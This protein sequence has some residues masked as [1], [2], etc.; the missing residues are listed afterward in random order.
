[1]NRITCIVGKTLFL[2]VLMATTSLLKAQHCDSIPNHLAGH[3][4]LWPVD[5]IQLADGNILIE[6]RQD[7][8]TTY[9]EN[10]EF[11]PC[12]VKYYKISRHGAAIIDS[13]VFEDL[14]FVGYLEQLH[15]ANNK[16]NNLM[17]KRSADNGSCLNIKFFDDD[18]NFNDEMEI[19]FPVPEEISDGFISI[20]DSNDDIILTYWNLAE[21]ETR[22]AR[23]GLD[24]TLKLTKAYPDSIMP[25]VSTPGN[26]VSIDGIIIKIWISRN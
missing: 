25:I 13:I 19:T 3:F 1:M 15:T 5:A 2:M 24:G 10:Q 16:Y 22:F 23:Y 8:L 11:I 9:D 14:D 26:I 18:L 20:L 12:L 4:C 6:C 17:I 7:S 21:S